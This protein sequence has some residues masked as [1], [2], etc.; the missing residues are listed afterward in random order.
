MSDRDFYEQI[1]DLIADWQ[2]IVEDG[3]TDDAIAVLSGAVRQIVQVAEDTNPGDY[4]T[5]VFNIV[6]H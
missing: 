4:H 3:I 1:I 5:E 2:M 6:H